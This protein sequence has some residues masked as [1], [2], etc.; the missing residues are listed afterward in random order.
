MLRNKKIFLLDIDG[1]VSVGNK[2]IEGTFEFLD[3][4]ASNG[5]KYIFITNNSSKSI[6]DYVEKF[7]GL[8][9]KV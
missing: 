9:F 1:T 6:D 7:N 3:Y 4:I 5:G 8:G 2:V